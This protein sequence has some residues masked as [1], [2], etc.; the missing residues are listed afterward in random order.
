MANVLIDSDTTLNPSSS[1]VQNELEKVSSATFVAVGDPP[2]G[3]TDNQLVGNFGGSGDGDFDDDGNIVQAGDT[4]RMDLGSTLIA[5]AGIKLETARSAQSG[6]GGELYINNSTVTT[7][8]LNAQTYDSTTRHV[9]DGIGSRRGTVTLRNQSVLN[10]GG[11]ANS[12][13]P[14]R[15]FGGARF[16]LR[17]DCEDSTINFYNSDGGNGLWTNNTYVIPVT[18]TITGTVTQANWNAFSAANRQLI[19]YAGTDISANRHTI[20]LGTFT[21]PTGNLTVANLVSLLSAAA[22]GTVDAFPN[23]DRVVLDQVTASGASAGIE[24]EDWKAF[25]NIP[26]QVGLS[27]ATS[28]GTNVSVA[29]GST[30]FT[31]GAASDFFGTERSICYLGIDSRFVNSVVQGMG[32]LE[33]QGN[34]REFANTTINFS[35]TS[36][37]DDA[38]FLFIGADGYIDTTLTGLVN[39]GTTAGVTLPDNYYYA[40]ITSQGGRMIFEGSIPSGIQSYRLGFNL[41]S[42]QESTGQRKGMQFWAPLTADVSRLSS[43]GVESNST[44]GVVIFDNDNYIGAR[45]TL[46]NGAAAAGTNFQWYHLSK[47]AFTGTGNSTDTCPIGWPDGRNDAANMRFFGNNTQRSTAV[48]AITGTPNSS[49]NT[50]SNASTSTQSA[51]NRSS[52]YRLWPMMAAAYDWGYTPHVSEELGTTTQVGNTAAPTHAQITNAEASPAAIRDGYA[53]EVSLNE[54]TLFTGNTAFDTQAEAAALTGMAIAQTSAALMTNT[55]TSSRSLEQIYAR[56]AAH[57]HETLST[58]VAA[59]TLPAVNSNA[60]FID[61]N[62]A[63]NTLGNLE[64]GVYTQD[65]TTTTNTNLTTAAV[66]TSMADLRGIRLGANYDQDVF[67][68]GWAVMGIFL[69]ADNWGIYEFRRP[70]D[71]FSYGGEEGGSL[72]PILTQGTTTSSANFR[73]RALV[74]AESIDQLGFSI[75]NNRVQYLRDEGLPI[76]RTGTVMNLSA[77][78]LT[79]GTNG[80]LT[81]T[82]G[83]SSFNLD[84]TST[85]A[86]GNTN[87]A[88]SATGSGTISGFN[89][90][91][92]ASSPAIAAGVT[93]GSGVTVQ[94]ARGSTYY[95]EGDISAAT[96][97]ATGSTGTVTLL[98]VG[99]GALPSSE[100]NNF[101]HNKSVTIS[102]TKPSG[103]WA[104]SDLTTAHIANISAFNGI[105]QSGIDPLQPLSS[106]TGVINEGSLTYNSSPSSAGQWEPGR[107]STDGA[108]TNFTDITSLPDSWDW[109]DSTNTNPGAA[110]Q[111][112]GLT[113]TERSTLVTFINTTTLLNKRLV[114]TDG[115]SNWAVYNL[116]N[117]QTTLVSSNNLVIPNIEPISSN[118]A[119]QST[120]MTAYFSSDTSGNNVTITQGNPLT[121]PTAVLS[122]SN[123]TASFTYTIGADE[124]LYYAFGARNG[125]SGNWYELVSG[126]TETDNTPAHTLTV[127]NTS[128][129]PTAFTTGAGLSTQN[130]FITNTS[131]EVVELL[132]QAPTNTD[133]MQITIDD[134][135]TTGTDAD[136]KY[137]TRLVMQKDHYLH[138]IAAG[139]IA[140]DAIDIQQTQIVYNNRFVT[141]QKETATTGIVSFN[142]PVVDSGNSGV[143][144]GTNAITTSNVQTEVRF[145]APTTVAFVSADQ[146][147]TIDTINSRCG[148]ILGEL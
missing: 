139:F 95:I 108:S 18:F 53:V 99:N 96:L 70:G 2:N 119:P 5:E 76:T 46:T 42:G 40:T 66:S 101:A 11:A 100:G 73:I 80:A 136:G 109:R 126:N 7:P 12:S 111:I 64:I 97:E 94:F 142:T 103:T 133:K 90:S 60:P 57:V 1:S 93:V 79:L 61:Q 140:V 21:S 36:N 104:A 85:V 31:A 51:N 55:V 4:L 56:T 129:V 143:N 28:L 82:T 52:T 54:E 105:T 131:N 30:T 13:H 124:N 137:A 116:D 17:I 50:V 22:T 25:T 49:T 102:F 10:M 43:A 20:Q 35:D 148:A 39:V 117:A 92:S 135:T 38:G 125:S 23:L 127:M 132:H 147:A 62:V 19:I 67:N 32:K 78:N 14:A 144:S 88:I 113:T 98:L 59:Y 123:A 44:G 6:D 81:T 83:L 8:S 112:A 33:F 63:T 145:A 37:L 141:W 121:D 71:S 130:T 29:A 45:S 68:L 89:T 128:D 72:E 75:T 47:A 26:Y 58:D 91:S 122:N 146:L 120:G 110:I 118:G 41:A 9:V 48:N 86:L 3:G 138:N 74:I 84:S 15:T 69:D 24:V 114:I 27:S 115:D 106:I 107:S 87:L 16:G 134:V 65:I 77:Y 34:F